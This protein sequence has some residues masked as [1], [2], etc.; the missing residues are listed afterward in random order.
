MGPSAPDGPVAL[1]AA[2]DEVALVV[3]GGAEVVAGALSAPVGA[4]DTRALDAVAA[5]WKV[6]AVAPRGDAV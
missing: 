5:G 3:D 1:V 2:L 6:A 4:G